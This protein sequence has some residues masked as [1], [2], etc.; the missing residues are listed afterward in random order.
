MNVQYTTVEIFWRNQ[1]PSPLLSQYLNEEEKEYE[2]GKEFV[3][4]ESETEVPLRGD[5]SIPGP[6]FGID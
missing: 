5:E 1:A 2:K 3:P 4:S 6:E